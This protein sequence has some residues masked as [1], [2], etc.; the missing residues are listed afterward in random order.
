MAKWEAGQ[1]GLVQFKVL[2][3]LLAV[4]AIGATS[5]TARGWFEDSRRLAVV[6]DREALA[7]EFRSDVAE[8]S[9]QVEDRLS[10]LRANE[11]VIDRGVI[12]EIQKPVYQR[13]CFEPELVRLLNAAQRGDADTGAAE[14]DTPMP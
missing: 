13:V 5:W 14:P 3:I 8:I 7:A 2:A 4:G 10:Q 12:R 11:R 1:S 9:R 6:A